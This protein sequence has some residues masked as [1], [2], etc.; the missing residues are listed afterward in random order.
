MG[1]SRRIA[2]SSGEALS[3]QNWWWEATNLP[4]GWPYLGP[5]W[6]LGTEKALTEAR[7]WHTLARRGGGETAW[8]PG[9]VFERPAALDWDPRTYLGWRPA[10]S[11]TGR[12][13]GPAEVDRL[14][15]ETFFPALVLGSPLG[16]RSEIAFT[17]WSPRLFA[18]MVDSGVRSA[19]DQGVRSVVAPW[20]PGRRGNR[21]IIAALESLGGHHAFWGYEDYLELT[22]ESY[23]EHIDMLGARK[24]KRYLDQLDRLAGAGVTIERVD[25]PDMRPLIPKIAELARRTPRHN[26]AAEEPEHISTVLAALLDAGAEVR[27]YTGRRRGDVVAV[28]VV[29]RK[30]FRLFIKWVGFDDDRLGDLGASPPQR[31]QWPAEHGGAVRAAGEEGERSFEHAAAYLALVLDAP[32]RDAYLEGCHIIECG[33]GARVGKATRGC[34]SRRLTTGLLLAAGSLR[35][36]SRDWLAAFGARRQAAYEPARQAR[37]RPPAEHRERRRD[38]R[39]APP[40]A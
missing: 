1:G 37:R 10:G 28:C 11:A 30:G 7:P 29:F 2:I 23:D 3:P 13:A 4:G 33:P 32:L 34:R 31:S 27:C 21:A 25:G 6:L 17:F 24:R 19:F 14:G 5:T 12:A 9:F 18:G 36:R 38:L 16:Y 35:E 20:I 22:A 39:P 40:A 8:L 15:T 26:V